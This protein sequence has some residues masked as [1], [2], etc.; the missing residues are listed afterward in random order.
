MEVIGI[1]GGVGCGKSAILSELEKNLNCVVLRADEAAMEL[2]KKGGV[3]YFSLVDLLGEDVLSQDGEIDRIKMASLVFDN[4]DL[5]KK[6]NDIVHPAVKEYI[7]D[8]IKYYEDC[9]NVDFFFLEA[10]LLIECGYNSIVDQMWYIF[11][12]KEVRIKRLKESRNYSEQK[13]DAIMNSQLSEEEFRANSDFV[14]D[15]SNSLEDSI[16]QIYKRVNHER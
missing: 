8:R 15:N 4:D 14:I 13:I 6:V 7:L 11:A 16:K 10:A 1:T 3:C 2:E 5:L 9:G 12:N